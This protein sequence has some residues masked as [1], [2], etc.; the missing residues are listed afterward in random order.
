[1]FEKTH[2]QPERA[3][4][5]FTL[6]ELLVVIAII[7]ILAGLLL[8]SLG[9]AKET[10]KKIS[11]GNNMKQLG[12]A[13]T[14]YAGDNDD[15]LPPRPL[16]I[17]EARWPGAM[18]AEY[19]N[20]KVLVCPSETEEPAHGDGPTIA[21]KSPRSYIINAF[22]DYYSELYNTLDFGKITLLMNSNQFRLNA[23]KNTSG[24]V[25]F[26]EKVTERAHFYMDFLETTAGND[27]TEVEQ[28]RHNNMITSNG[29]KG[30]GGSNYIF[31][32][33]S[34]Q[35]FRYGKC[36]SPINYWAITDKWRNAGGQ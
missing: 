17:Q 29:N 8:P 1:M 15:G 34:L 18:Y 6:I 36:L 33:N 27:F 28:G 3:R 35:Y 9:R 5:G 21:D 24:V 19:S 16:G 23:V 30:G 20:L 7:A 10:A 14:L 26:G 25:L 22:N 12:L 32:D 4:A 11:C 2:F 13:A 31:C